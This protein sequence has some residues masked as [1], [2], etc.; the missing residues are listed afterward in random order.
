[1][2]GPEGKRT[3]GRPR[4]SWIDT[5]EMTLQEVRFRGRDWIGLPQNRD[6][7]RALVSAAMNLRVP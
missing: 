2:G 5:I 1:M 7:W 6:S 4:C 3:L